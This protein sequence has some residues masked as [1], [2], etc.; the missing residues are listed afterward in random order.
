MSLKMKKAIF[1]DRDGTLIEDRGYV[2]KIEDLKLLPGIIEG[3]K[4]LQHQFLL[5]IIT[6]Q[7]GIERGFYTIDVFHRFNNFFLIESSIF[8][9][10]PRK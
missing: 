3:L 9:N 5:Y 6:N 7:S 4:I 2:H 10:G 1:L 8:F